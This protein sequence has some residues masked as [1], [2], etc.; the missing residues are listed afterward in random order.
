MLCYSSDSLTF[1]SGRLVVEDD[2]ILVA[3]GSRVSDFVSWV[4]LSRGMS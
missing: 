4:N 2:L 1:S 3:C